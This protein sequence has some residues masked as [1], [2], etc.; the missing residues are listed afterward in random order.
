MAEPIPQ[1]IMPFPFL[2]LPSDLQ[3]HLMELCELPTLCNLVSSSKSLRQLYSKNSASVFK[4][5][6]NR[7]PQQTQRLILTVLAIRRTNGGSIPLHSLNDYLNSHLDDITPI[8]NVP[9]HLSSQADLRLLSILSSEIDLLVSLC[10]RT[11]L[12]KFSK[13]NES[14]CSPLSFNEWHRMVRALWRLHLMLLLNN[15]VEA[16]P[17]RI[18]GTGSWFAFFNR[19]ALWEK[20]EMFEM[21]LFICRMIRYVYWHHHPRRP[22]HSIL[23]KAFHERSGRRG[24]L[25]FFQAFWNHLVDIAAEETPS[26][27][28]F[29][30]GKSIIWP[31]TT[32][33]SQP[34]SVSEPICKTSWSEAAIGYT[35]I[36]P[37]NLNSLV[38][39]RHACWVFW[40][41]SRL[42]KLFGP[43]KRFWKQIE[44]GALQGLETRYGPRYIAY[45]GEL[46]VCYDKVPPMDAV[47]SLFEL[48]YRSGTP[49]KCRDCRKSLDSP[50]CQVREEGL[51]L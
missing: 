13:V 43:E 19:L 44:H 8:S 25:S 23:N 4:N 42:E 39:A 17:Y 10:F 7:W 11:S 50:A 21:A 12:E 40:D 16:H 6:L 36:L 29:D 26:K 30:L 14:N 24:D 1:A 22:H 41:D 27:Q 47:Q 51:N 48:W 18:D 33:A 28:L 5:I 45:R 49:A 32:E 15:H 35:E 20:E 37:S 46:V 3:L 2:R 34:T 9:Q 31:D 38:L